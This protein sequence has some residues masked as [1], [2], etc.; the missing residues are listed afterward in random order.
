MNAD[1]SLTLLAYISRLLTEDSAL[2]GLLTMN[3]VRASIPQLHSVLLA[4]AEKSAPRLRQSCPK[5]LW[6]AVAAGKTLR[7]LTPEQQGYVR[8]QT[9]VSR[10]NRASSL[11]AARNR[12]P[13]RLTRRGR[14]QIA[15]V[16]LQRAGLGFEED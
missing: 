13:Y 15:A 3:E 12:K 2:W 8:S 1:I 10:S 14:A 9:R 7:E 4:K 16:K 5:E 11:E 6:D